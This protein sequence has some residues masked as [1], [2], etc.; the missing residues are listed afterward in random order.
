MKA[1][2]EVRRI[3]VWTLAMLVLILLYAIFGGLTEPFPPDVPDSTA[4]WLAAVG[5]WVIGIGAT[6]YAHEAMS[7]RMAQQ[8]KEKEGRL[9]ILMSA[10]NQLA[11]LHRQP[12]QFAVDYENEVRVDFLLSLM[13]YIERVIETA[14]PQVVGSMIHFPH[15]SGAIAQVQI[16]CT[17]VQYMF[18]I[19]REDLNKGEVD[20]A[21]QQKAL[22][23]VQSHAR[24]VSEPADYLL[25]QAANMGGDLIDRVVQ[26][27]ANI[28]PIGGN[29]RR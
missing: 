20:L 21:M 24:D 10:S 17:N 22:D 6:L 4:D 23:V 7:S 5:A 25:R 1:V 13:N 8:L 16:A 11:I 15:L 27:M 18:E 19:V 28:G 26:G 3:T 14:T 29:G 12:D 9:G 2:I